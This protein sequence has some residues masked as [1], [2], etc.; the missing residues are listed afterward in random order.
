MAN[1]SAYLAKIMS[2][3]YGEEVRSSIHDSI[4]AMNEESSNAMA[5]ASSAKDSAAA[6][7][8][9]AAQSASDAAASAASAASA[10]SAAEKAKTAA[11][12]AQSAAASSAS[13]AASSAS[14]ASESAASASSDAQAAEKARDSVDNKVEDVM[15]M[16]GNLI[17]YHAILQG[18]TDSDESALLDSSGN[19][20]Q[21]QTVYA[22]FQDVLD[23]KRTVDS[24]VQY[25][26][27]LTDTFFI[28]RVEALEK[29]VSEEVEVNIAVLKEHALL[30][31]TYE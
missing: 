21:G 7:A 19:Q 15:T 16:K 4:S 13:S 18:L 20:I 24:L 5:Y 12:S 9:A 23:L 28:N 6:S 22:D 27:N 8:S 2:A 31:S 1:I 17:N 10:Q 14:A 30:D 11:Q 26:K 3:V 29:K 25:I